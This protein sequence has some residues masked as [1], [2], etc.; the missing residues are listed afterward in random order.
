MLIIFGCGAF[1]ANMK[2]MTELG[3]YE[4]IADGKTVWMVDT[5]YGDLYR[6]SNDYN[7]H[8]DLGP[9]LWIKVQTVPQNL[10]H[11]VLREEN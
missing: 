5:K 11:D 1:V 10:V 4:I 2:P 9:N 6:N 3:R 7:I 8:D